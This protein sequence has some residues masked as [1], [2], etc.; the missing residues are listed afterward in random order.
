MGQHKNKRKRLTKIRHIVQ[1]PTPDDF[2]QEE[3]WGVP[4]D[5]LR[6][7]RAFMCRD[8]IEVRMRIKPPD[9]KPDG[10]LAEISLEFDL[11]EW[12]E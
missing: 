2:T 3:L 7:G 1:P 9:A 8:D 10:L 12:M 5:P 4:G 6:P 11:P